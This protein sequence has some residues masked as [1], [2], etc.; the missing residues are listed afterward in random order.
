LNLLKEKKIDDER[1]EKIKK[2]FELY[3]KKN[4]NDDISVKQFVKL[5][6]CDLTNIELCKFI[7][8]IYIDLYKLT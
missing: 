6:V 4:N 1:I 7:E 3:K 5:L 8:K 2:L